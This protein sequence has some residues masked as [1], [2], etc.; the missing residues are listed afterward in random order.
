M[1]DGPRCACGR[2][3]TDPVSVARGYG[4]VCARRR[5]I[6]PTPR[7]RNARPGE[8]RS[9]PV[10]GSPAPDVHPGQTAT[11]IQMEI[12]CPSP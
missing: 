8:R 2:A 6:R 12:T 10:T 7:T 4:P 5:G 11:P 9:D 3:L 1:T